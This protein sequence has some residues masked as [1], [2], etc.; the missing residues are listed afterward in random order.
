MEIPKGFTV[1]D[2]KSNNFVLK[3]HKN[4]YEQKQAGRVWNQHLVSK[5]SSIGFKQ[6]KADDCLFYKDKVIYAL[7][8]DDSILAAESETELESL[9]FHCPNSDSC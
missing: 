2:E 9:L 1:D 6:C 8:T 3:F 7:Y 4:I 5:L